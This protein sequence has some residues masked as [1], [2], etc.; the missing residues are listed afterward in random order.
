MTEEKTQPVGL[1]CL[2]DKALA[3]IVEQSLAEHG[4]LKYEAVTA[5]AEL[6]RRTSPQ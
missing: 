2:S 1:E 6:E 3:A 4:E 5:F